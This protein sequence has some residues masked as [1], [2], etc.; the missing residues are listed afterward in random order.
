MFLLH[1]MS[2]SF[3]STFSLLSSCSSSSPDLISTGMATIMIWNQSMYVFF[4][5]CIFLFISLISSSVFALRYLSFTCKSTYL[6]LN[7]GSQ[8]NLI[9]PSF[10]SLPVVPLLI[11]HL[12]LNLWGH[13]WLLNFPVSSPSASLIMSSYNCFSFLYPFITFPLPSSHTLML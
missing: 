5:Y 4:I 7:W 3:A 9:F 11:S 12:Q 2:F 1:L 13:L 8:A 6:K 10:M